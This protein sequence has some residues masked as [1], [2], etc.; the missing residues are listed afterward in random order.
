MVTKSLIPS[1]TAALKWFSNLKVQ[2][3]FLEQVWHGDRD[4]SKLLVGG[5][6]EVE[7]TKIVLHLSPGFSILKL[8]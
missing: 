2:R 4:L 7:S 3:Q 8:V 1:R 5:L 6:M